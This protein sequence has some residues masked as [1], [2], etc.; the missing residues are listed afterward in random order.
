[1]FVNEGGQGSV[2][3]FVESIGFLGWIINQFRSKEICFH[4]SLSILWYLQK[5]TAALVWDLGVE[6]FRVK[7]TEKW[8]EKASVVWR[9]EI[10]SHLDLVKTWSRVYP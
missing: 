6:K 7:L 8:S 5:V 3:L 1:M 2:I 9:L 10:L 4:F